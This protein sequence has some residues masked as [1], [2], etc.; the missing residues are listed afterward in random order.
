M[1]AA[2][3]TTAFVFGGGGRWGAV[4]VGMLRALVAAGIEPDLI[5]GTSIGAMNGA[6]FASDP[7]PPG[8]ATVERLWADA[9]AKG[10]INA[11]I[12]DRVRTFARSRIAIQETEPLRGL[13]REALP[14]DR[15]EDLAVPFQCVAASIERA[16]E[17]WFTSGPLIEAILAS[18]AVPALFAPVAIDGEHFYD[19][20]LVNSVPVDRAVALGATT[21]FVLQ[22][23][24]I[25][26]PLRVPSKFWEPALVA[27]EIARRHR[28][29]TAQTGVP[30]EVAVHLLPSGNE[31]AFDDTRQAK[32]SDMSETQQLIAAA[33]R[34]SAEY[35]AAAGLA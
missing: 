31:V 12:V 16:T 14:V 21:V 13:L 25:E 11:R 19:G 2:R 26:Q 8:L 29:V 30:E 24:R 22:V 28:F 32:W 10:L 3:P 33:H 15:I 34:A 9:A 6:V 17:H 18:S 5:V 23:G 1:P 27:F 4:E 7:G 35:L 20:G